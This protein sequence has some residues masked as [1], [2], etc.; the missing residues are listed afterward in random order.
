MKSYKGTIS[1]MLVCSVLLF[2]LFIFNSV[3]LVTTNMDVD[4]DGKWNS[5]LCNL[6]VVLMIVWVSNMYNWP[7]DTKKV[8]GH[9]FHFQIV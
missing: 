9:C 7:I 8:E 1:F 3:L 4:R 2:N 5:V 6:C